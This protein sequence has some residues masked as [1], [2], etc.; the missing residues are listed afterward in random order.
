MAKKK[1]KRHMTHEEE[2][3]IMKLVLD[4][5]LWLGVGIMALGFYK[6]ISLNE[7]LIYGLSVLVAGAI[8]LVLFMIILVR[9]YNFLTK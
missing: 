4:K 7:N 5:F 1:M 2:F 9:E 6:M 3:D 8:L